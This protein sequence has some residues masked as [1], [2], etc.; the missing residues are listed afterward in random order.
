MAGDEGRE[1]N[2]EYEGFE[3]VVVGMYTGWTT[4]GHIHAFSLSA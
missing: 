4:L 2:V 1:N 3:N